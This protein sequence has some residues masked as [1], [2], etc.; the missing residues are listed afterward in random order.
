MLRSCSLIAFICL[1]AGLFSCAGQALQSGN[2]DHLITYPQWFLTPPIDLSC[3]VGYARSYFHRQSSIEQAIE[4]AIDQ[5]ARQY[6]VDIVGGRI[7]IDQ[8]QVADFSEVTPSALRKQVS[9][10][11][12]VWA[13][14]ET[15]QLLLVLIGNQKRKLTTRKTLASQKKPGWLSN[16][17]VNDGFIYGV[18]NCNPRYHP[19]I[20]WQTAEKH[21]RINLAV[22]LQAKIRHLGKYATDYN[23][24]IA[25]TEIEVRLKNIAVVARWYDI[26]D[27]SYH[28]LIRVADNK[29]D[30]KTVK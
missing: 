18:G 9:N 7:T 4:N 11:Y 5:L 2:E 3:A 24:Q 22:N 19:E 27:R 20:G 1:T 16:R 13:T 15:P 30:R 6:Q 14:Y 10:Q 21:A 17:P 8:V 23:E 12:H 28:V 29:T 26:E 25:S